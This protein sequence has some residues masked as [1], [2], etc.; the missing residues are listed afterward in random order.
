MKSWFN[1]HINDVLEKLMS[2]YNTIENKR[3]LGGIINA[4]TVF[5]RDGFAY[6]YLVVMVSK[7][8]ISISDFVLYFGAIAGF[9]SWITNIIRNT[10]EISR[11]SYKISHVRSFFDMKNQEFKTFAIWLT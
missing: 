8:N 3:L 4:I 2:F 7:G 1:S 6:I 9:S 5:L 10:H 11:A